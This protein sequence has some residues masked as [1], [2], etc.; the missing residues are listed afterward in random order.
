MVEVD[1]AAFGNRVAA[2]REKLGISQTALAKAVGMRQQG[3]DAIEQGRVK[4]PRLLRELVSALKTTED[5]LLW[6]KGPEEPPAPQAA[7]EADL[8]RIPLLDKV[9]AGKL[10]AS[11]SQ[12]PVEDVPL[13]AFADLGRGDFFALTVDGD[14][15]DRWSPDGSIIV[16]NQADRTLVSGKAYVISQRGEA[17]FKMWRPDPPRFAPYSTNP[18]HEPIFVRS[19]AEAEKLVVGRVK[20]TVLDL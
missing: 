15:M 4:R 3:I 7:T 14:S 9:T 19:K 11:S 2:R 16:V 18:S 17:T 10:R 20:R 1:P 12:I 13:L 5:W 6:R 8:R